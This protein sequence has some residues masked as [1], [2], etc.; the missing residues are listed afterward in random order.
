MGESLKICFDKE[1]T[2]QEKW[3]GIEVYLKC[4]EIYGETPIVLQG[5]DKDGEPF[6][7]LQ[8]TTEQY[9]EIHK[10]SKK[11]KLRAVT[12]SDFSSEEASRLM[13]QD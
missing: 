12:F 5:V 7:Y 9:K 8:M 6:V 13:N 10:R 4:A 11:I 1:L 3:H 2:P